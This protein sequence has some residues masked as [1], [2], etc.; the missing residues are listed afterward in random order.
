M[1][2]LGDTLRERRVALGITLEQAEEHTKI[3][4]KLLAALENGDYGR[5][6]EPGLRPWLHLELRALSRP[7]HR[8][9]ARDVPRRDRRGPLPRD[10]P[11]GHRGLGARRAACGPVACRRHRGRG[12]GAAVARHLGD[13]QADARPREAAAHPDHADR[14]DLDD[15]AWRRGHRGD[16][17]GRRPAPR[18]RRE[19]HAVHPEGGGR[20]GRRIVDRRTRRRQGLRT[21]DTLTGGDSK[22]FEV[23]RKAVLKIGRPSVV[24]V[25]RDGKKVAIPSSG[26]TPTLTLT[27]EPAP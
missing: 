14:G 11:A 18:S 1:S 21:P 9:A 4:G 26:G 12:A 2:Q 3:R 6:P 20:R 23:T 15:V 16:V 13:A 8:A 25:Y 27:A 7:R 19:V 24:T 5:L 17:S 22:S 10:R